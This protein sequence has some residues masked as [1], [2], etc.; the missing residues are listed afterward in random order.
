MSSTAEFTQSFLRRGLECFGLLPQLFFYLGKRGVR[1]FIKE[2]QRF[3]FLVLLQADSCKLQI[4]KIPVRR[5]LEKVLPGYLRLFP[6]GVRD[7]IECFRVS[8][9]IF[10]V[11]RCKSAGLAKLKKSASQQF[12]RI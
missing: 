5:E 7:S 9:R 12:C 10:Q 3:R 1:N 6:I 2:R 8:S 11:V 4:S